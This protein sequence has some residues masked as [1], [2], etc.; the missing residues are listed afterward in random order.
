MAVLGV[1][2]ACTLPAGAAAEPVDFRYGTV[3]HRYTTTQPNTSTGFSYTGTYHA[4]GDPAGDP[5]YMRKMVFYPP[6]GLRY[7]T[8]VPE[9]CT[10]SDIQLQLEGPSACPAGSRLGG[11]TGRAKFMGEESSFQID[12]FNNTNE[13]VMVIHSPLIATVSRGR[14]APDGTIE[15]ASPTCYPA[16]V[17]C[18]T[19]TVLQTGSSVTTQPYTRDGR[20]YTTTPPKCPKAGHWTSSIRFWWADGAEDTVVTKQPC[21]R[22]AAKKKP[23]RR[24]SRSR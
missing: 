8:S 9:R 18:P 22:P 6:P 5:P 19:D 10:A 11:G 1:A 16:L 21:T 13:Q 12:V 4:A 15:Y 7:D 14:I 20:G 2:A 3:D 24:R 23:K 17:T